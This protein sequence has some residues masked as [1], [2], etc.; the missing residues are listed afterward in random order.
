M[1]KTLDEE[2]AHFDVAFD[3]RE[4]SRQRRGSLAEAAGGPA[5]VAAMVK[6]AGLESAAKMGE[7]DS[8][9]AFG[10][11][12]TDGEDF[13]VGLHSI[14][15]DDQEM[16]VINWQAGVAE[17]YFKASVGDPKGVSLKRT[18]DTDGNA[19]VSFNDLVFADLARRV[20]ELSGRDQWGID[21]ALLSDLDRGRSGEMADIVRT[22]HAAQY[23][24]IR[25]PLDQALVIQ[26]GPGTGKT[27][28][29]L[30]RVSWLLYNEEG[31]TAS[32]V[33]VVGPNPMF[34][35]YIRN[36][37]PTLGDQDVRHM[38]LPELGPLKASDRT[39]EGSLRELK[40]DSRMATLLRRGVRQRVRLS[41]RFSS[42]PVGGA[43][44]ATFAREEIERVIERGL[45]R[46]TYNG[47]RALFRDYIATESKQ[48]TRRPLTAAQ[49]D[50]AV[51]RVWPSHTPQS[52]L[53]ELLGS[54]EALINAAGDDFTASEA[55]MLVRAPSEKVSE[56]RWSATDVALMDELEWLIQGSPRK[57]SHVVVDE[58][59][60][61]SPMQWRSIRRRCPDESY[62]IVGD[63]AQ[64]TQPWSP[65]DWQSVGE[66]LTSADR[67]N[68]VTLDLGYRV[69]RQIFELAAQLLPVAAPGVT[70]PTVV[71]T[72]PEDPELIEDESDSLVSWAVAAAQEHAE[73]GR[74]V[75]VVCP[76]KMWDGL[77]EEL[78]DQGIDFGDSAG[79]LSSSINLMNAQESKGLEFDAVVVVNP[80]LIVQQPRGHRLLY[81]AMTRTTQYLTVVHTGS[82]LGSDHDATQHVEVST[83][84][85]SGPPQGGTAGVS[86][87]IQTRSEGLSA[88]H[89][90][91][92]AIAQQLAGVVAANVSQIVRQNL[93][94][95][96]WP[97][98][99]Q[100]LYADLLGGGE[101]VS[102]KPLASGT[103]SSDTTP[104]A[105]LE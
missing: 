103:T 23:E 35:R 56:E 89:A 60:D 15:D 67:V 80:E 2:Q 96:V 11:F 39:E 55:S 76:E 83:I 64:G 14:F 93:A 97:L 9:V 34:T 51:D 30:H 70:V 68:I 17:P 20:E 53:R 87:M 13:Y 4:E 40:G 79:E 19:V 77:A 84:E 37:L 65:D 59:Q 31:L 52:F 85:E 48:R 72:G 45:E 90:E 62:T 18:F 54:R 25:Q 102:P 32:D 50:Q 49:V 22:I 46:A 3:A 38:S 82:P 6:Q 33:L 27:V 44:G 42:L 88:P 100:M 66:R 41:D 86:G 58:A 98:V 91:P 21:D 71:R 36:V 29:A 1:T 99:M 92:D 61:L 7:P 10:R 78:L 8:A 12:E 73:Q 63:L 104:Q 74:F 95:T 47:G 26:G 16:L 101:G 94:P 69:P 43:A 75:G 5:K 24:L 105:V 28:V 57:Y 81:I